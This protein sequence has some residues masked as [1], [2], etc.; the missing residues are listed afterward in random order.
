MKRNQ[1]GASLIVVLVLLTVLLFGVVSLARMGDAATLMAGSTASQ[2]AALAASEVGLAEAAAALDTLADPETEEVEW[3][4]PVKLTDDAAGLPD[5]LAWAI[6]RSKVVGQ[7]TVRY[8]VERL[9][10]GVLPVPATER[11]ARCAIKK[12]SASESGSSKAGTEALAADT[13]IQYRT[14][15]FVL[16]PKETTVYVQALSAL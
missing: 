6:K 14:T 16:G 8:Q 5:G 11:S 3:Y 4:S 13:Q 15:V 10:T 9:C 1:Q 2:S 7:Y 12:G